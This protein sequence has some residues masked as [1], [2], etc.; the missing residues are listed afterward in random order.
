MR[1]LVIALV[2]LGCSSSSRG[3]EPAPSKDAA[4]VEERPELPSEEEPFP[5][6]EEPDAPELPADAAAE[7]ATDARTDGGVSCDP[8][9]T[10]D[11]GG[12]RCTLHQF[13]RTVGLVGT[14]VDVPAAER[15]TPCS[16]QVRCPAGTTR[17]ILGSPFEGCTVVCR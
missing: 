4:P 15:C 11:C 14:C 2:V 10:F 6:P 8:S 5:V 1:I 7:V 17:S 12:V 13:C 3:G 16:T 9:K